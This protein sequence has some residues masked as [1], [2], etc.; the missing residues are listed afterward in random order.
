MD[1]T[2]SKVVMVAK[3]ETWLKCFPWIGGWF[4]F[5]WALAYFISYLVMNY[6]TYLHVIVSLFR[7]DPGK[8]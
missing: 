5:M 7:V 8:G 6:L 2:Q 1:V 3:T 4:V